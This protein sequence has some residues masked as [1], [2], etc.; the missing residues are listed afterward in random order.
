MKVER[1]VKELLDELRKEARAQKPIMMQFINK[2]YENAPEA[3]RELRCEKYTES[4]IR[5]SWAQAGLMNPLLNDEMKE[6]R[7]TEIVKNAIIHLK[8][9]RYQ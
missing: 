3:L 9:V 2:L 8:K 5:N 1:T 4:I 6:R 7:L